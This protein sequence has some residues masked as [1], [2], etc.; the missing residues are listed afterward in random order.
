[1]IFFLIQIIFSEILSKTNSQSILCNETIENIKQ[2]NNYIDYLKYSG[3]TLD[4]YGFYDQ[5]KKIPDSYY[6]LASFV[7]SQNS[8]FKIIG[9][10]FSKNCSSKELFQSYKKIFSYL[11][12]FIPNK[13][14]NQIVANRKSSWKNVN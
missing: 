11:Q 14:E 10:C 12:I 7:N 8:K 3:K 6:S 9:I 13:E 4:E 2:S 1:M 5:C